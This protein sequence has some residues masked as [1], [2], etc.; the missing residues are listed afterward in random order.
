MMDD[1]EGDRLPYLILVN[2]F[3]ADIARNQQ[4]CHKLF[5]L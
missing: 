1:Q 3:G 5:M 4:I 2:M